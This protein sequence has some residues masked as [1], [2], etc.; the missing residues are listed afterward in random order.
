MCNRAKMGR[1]NTKKI[2]G[3]L[4][5]GRILF[6]LALFFSLILSASSTDSSWIF[7]REKDGIK[8]YTRKA[9][10]DNL[11]SFKG[12]ADINAPADKVFELIENINDTTWWDKNL[13]HIRILEYEKNK[14]REYYMVYSSPWPL[15]DRDLCI[16][17]TITTDPATGKSVFKSV[18]L[19]NCIPEQ[20]GRI[21]I[22]EFRQTWTIIP[23]GKDMTHVILE[24]F[25]DPM[26]AIP[27][28]ISN[29]VI[30]NSPYKVITNLRNHVER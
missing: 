2:S 10:G 18:S 27:D 11:E 22:K 3:Y 12:E 24:G 26:G 21:R 19:N 16:K 6:V 20:K 23:A 25:F 28:W 4:I 1:V 7:V 15:A 5:Q 9:A 17:S 14:S 8:I 30:T 13:T 29:I